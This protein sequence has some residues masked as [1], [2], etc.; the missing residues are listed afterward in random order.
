MPRRMPYRPDNEISQTYNDGVVT[1][2]RQTDAAQPGYQPKPALT[3]KGSLPFAEMR[4]GVTRMYL[5]RQAQAEIVRVLR[6]QRRNIS[7][8]DVAVT[9][10]GMQYRVD[11]VQAVED[12]WPPSVDISLQVLKQKLEVL[13]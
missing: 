12:V 2:Y 11:A 8:Q 13:P 7:P 3:K 9:Q 10:D 6:V 4:L 5:S 1:I